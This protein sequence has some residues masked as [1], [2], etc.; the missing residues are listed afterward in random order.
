MTLDDLENEALDQS[1]P[2]G[3]HKFNFNKPTEYVYLQDSLKLCTQIKAEDIV[4]IISIIESTVESNQFGFL[5]PYIQETFD[6]IGAYVAPDEGSIKTLLDFIPTFPVGSELCGERTYFNKY[7]VP[8][9]TCKMKLL[10]WDMFRKM[11]EEE[12][13]DAAYEGLPEYDATLY[14]IY[15]SDGRI[16]S[17][18]SIDSKRRIF[19][20]LDHLEK[21]A[22]E[23][24][25]SSKVVFL[26]AFY[27][28]FAHAILDV[29][30]EY[31]YTGKNLFEEFKEDSL[32]TG[33]ALYMLGKTSEISPAEAFGVYKLLEDQPIS[34]QIGK[35]YDNEDLLK[36]AIPKWK[37]LKRGKT[38]NATA[39]TEWYKCVSSRK[40]S[41]VNLTRIE[42]NL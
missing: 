11:A 25:T 41:K 40:H 7:K 8:T 22:D 24:S 9:D 23:L 27:Q 30:D 42:N 36:V 38:V 20:W 17:Y 32:A 18:L 5:A 37:D 28:A 15:Q 34:C 3:I 16:S 10:T 35:Y 13:M 4:K 2:Y 12:C 1:L 33:I 26:F 21:M 39:M 6:R 31:A 19:I 29:F 14:S